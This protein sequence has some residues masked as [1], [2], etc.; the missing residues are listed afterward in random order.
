[1]VYEITYSFSACFSDLTTFSHFSLFLDFPS[2]HWSVMN[3]YSSIKTHL[4]GLHLCEYSQAELML[5][6]S[7]QQCLDYFPIAIIILANS[8]E[9]QLCTRHCAQH[10]MWMIAFNTHQD[11]LRWTVLPSPFYR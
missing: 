6:P 4:G 1:M 7:V 3:S 8:S 10:F 2:S 5:L 9:C 11:P